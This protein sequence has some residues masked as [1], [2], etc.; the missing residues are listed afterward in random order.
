MLVLPL[1]LSA[2]VSE[3]LCATR[4]AATASTIV[5]AAN[6]K[7]EALN[8]DWAI[9]ACTDKIAEAKKYAKATHTEP[10][11]PPICTELLDFE[12]KAVEA[13][14]NRLKEAEKAYAKPPPAPKID[15]P[16]PT[17]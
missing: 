2:C 13:A 16:L 12:R 14:T 8:H 6:A 5:T 1:L 17:H 7:I 15:A 11:I 9:A 10:E 4:Q 3:K